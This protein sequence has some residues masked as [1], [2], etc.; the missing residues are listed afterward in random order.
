MKSWNIINL[1]EIKLVE[2]VLPRKEGEVKLKVSKVALSSTDVSYFAGKQEGVNVPGHSAIAYVSEADEQLGLKLGSRAVISP[3]VTKEEHGVKTVKILG[4]DK[5]GLLQDFVTVPQ[6]N[7]YVLPES[8]PDE[9]AIFAEYIAFGIKIFTQIDCD[10]GDYVVILGASTLGLIMSQLAVYY[11]MVPILIDL[12]ADKLALAEKWGV[13][14]TINPTY[15][16]L[17]RKVEEITGGRMSDF[18]VFVGEGISFN[19]ALRLIK[20]NGVAVIGGYNTSLVKHQIDMDAVLKKQLTVKG[21]GNGDGEMPSAIN[22][23]ANKIIATD[24]IINYRVDFGEVPEMVAQC[25]K[26]PYQYNK[27]LVSID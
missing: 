20:D 11:Q 17:E 16:S 15:D 19:S 4:V 18:A 5:D 6:E 3:F 21:I 22:L 23:L 24:G 1:N 2:D 13:Y 8:I 14:Y 12:D 27:I 7:V 25:V 10:K 26:Y 9:E